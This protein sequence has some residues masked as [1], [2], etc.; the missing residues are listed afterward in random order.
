MSNLTISIFNNKI[1]LEI[2]NE[3]KLFSK[4]KFRH[5]ED[6]DMCVKNAEKQGFMDGKLGMIIDSTGS[7]FRKVRKQKQEFPNDS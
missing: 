1:F 4:F 5:Y 6:L 2:I 3:I 7:N